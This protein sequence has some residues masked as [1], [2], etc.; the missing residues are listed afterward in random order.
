METIKLEEIKKELR[1]IR[2]VL[3]GIAFLL[4]P[5]LTILMGK[6]GVESG[7]IMFFGYL[8]ILPWIF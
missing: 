2:N 5:F 8:T 3:V 1:R 7:V 4:V 6:N